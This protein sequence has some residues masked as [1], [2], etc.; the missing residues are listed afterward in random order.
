[1]ITIIRKL[2]SEGLYGKKKE[3]IVTYGGFDLRAVCQFGDSL[4]LTGKQS[5]QVIILSMNFLRVNPI[6]YSVLTTLFFLKYINREIVPGDQR[7][8]R[9]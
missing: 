5:K 1:M 2:Q 6:N 8:I 4:N 9:D 7:L 3:S